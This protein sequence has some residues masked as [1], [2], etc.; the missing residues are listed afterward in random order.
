MQT[1]W[2]GEAFNFTQLCESN[3]WYGVPP[4]DYS[5]SN[6][7]YTKSLW[8]RFEYRSGIQ[9]GSTKVGRLIRELYTLNDAAIN[10]ST[11]HPNY[12]GIKDKVWGEWGQA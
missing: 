8:W 2:S 9:A 7:D 3:G 4:I 6:Y 12:N 11:A 5:T 10:P 1:T